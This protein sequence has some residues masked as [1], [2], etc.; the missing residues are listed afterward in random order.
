MVH[1]PAQAKF[2]TEVERTVALR[3]MKEDSHGATTEEDA[4]NERFNWHWVRMA[5]I[6]P[7]TIICS[8]AWFFLLIPI[9][10]RS[11]LVNSE[12]TTDTLDKASSS[13]C[14]LL[15]V[16]WGIPQQKPSYSAVCSEFYPPSS[17]SHATDLNTVPPNFCAF[18]CILVAATYSDKVKAR[19]QVHDCRLS[20]RNC[21][22][23]HDAGREGV[24]HPVWRN[25]PYR[26]RRLSRN[27]HVSRPG[28]IFW[29]PD[30]LTEIVQGTRLALE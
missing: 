8:L 21:R 3:R 20:G 16:I 4:R 30:L 10:V 24:S 23:H 17:L 25:I 2:L 28:C 6:S 7:N 5:L 26:V 15:W 29:W 9:Y 11:V 13:S 12:N 1:T 19:G 27:T 14:Q 18:L 22:L